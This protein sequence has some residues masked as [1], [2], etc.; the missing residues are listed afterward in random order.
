M[1][2]KKEEI[3][4]AMQTGVNIQITPKKQFPYFILIIILFIVLVLILIFYLLADLILEKNPKKHLENEPLTLSDCSKINWNSEEC[5]NQLNFGQA[6]KTCQSLT[7]LEKDNCYLVGAKINIE[8]YYCEM[9]DE[10][11]IKS[12]CIGVV[13]SLEVDLIEYE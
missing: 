2:S 11:N 5:L 13:N 12:D 1:Q 7:S 4:L 9:I 6:I 8:P 10:P 3:D